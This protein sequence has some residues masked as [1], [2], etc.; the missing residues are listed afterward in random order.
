MA[1]KK[2]NEFKQYIKENSD[3]DKEIQNS[4]NS[5]KTDKASEEKSH[6]KTMNGILIEFAKRVGKNNTYIE[7]RSYSAKSDDGNVNMGI[8]NKFQVWLDQ[9]RNS[10][11]EVQMYDTKKFY[12]QKAFENEDYDDRYGADFYIDVNYDNIE[13]TIQELVDMYNTLGTK[14]IS[15]NKEIWTKYGDNRAKLAQQNENKEQ[16]SKQSE[17]KKGFNFVSLTKGDTIKNEDGHIHVVKSVGFRCA[18]IENK[19]S[20]KTFD[21]SSLKGY[22]PVKIK[23]ID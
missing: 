8:F 19:K 11:L 22:E 14:R 16:K 2:F 7:P 13:E 15:D 20:N 21:I 18:T 4:K 12:V 9:N 23:N 17:I 10:W 1:T 3:Y 5:E 6:M